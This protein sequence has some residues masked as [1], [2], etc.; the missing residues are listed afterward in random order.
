[1]TNPDEVP[2]LRVVSGHPTPAELAALV[3]ALAALPPV[4]SS[5]VRAAPATGWSDRARGLR[6]S[7]RPGPRA[8]SLS[9]REGA[10]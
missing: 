3:V 8:W 6:R 10:G 9:G 4:T 5:R 7:L 1:M 2:L